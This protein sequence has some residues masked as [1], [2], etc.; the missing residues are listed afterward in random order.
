MIPFQREIRKRKERKRKKKERKRKKKERKKRKK[1]EKEKK[2]KREKRKEKK[3]KREK[4]KKNKKPVSTIE[5]FCTTIICEADNTVDNLCAITIIVLSILNCLR[6]K[7]K[8]MVRE[9]ERGE[10]E[11][12][13][14]FLLIS[15]YFLRQH[16]AH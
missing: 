4:E 16:Q 13:V 8:K 12:L 14:R 7:K 15:D 3:R 5:P 9:R 2:R 1:R 10:R 11:N 6:Q